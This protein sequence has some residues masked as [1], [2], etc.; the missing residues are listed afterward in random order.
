MDY[1]RRLF[2]PHFY[3]IYLEN[4]LDPNTWKLL[5]VNKIIRYLLFF[6]IFYSYHILW[7]HIQFLHFQYTYIFLS[8]ALPWFQGLMLTQAISSF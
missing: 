1:R 3:L 5:H 2:P 4:I 8:W 6:Y 7:N